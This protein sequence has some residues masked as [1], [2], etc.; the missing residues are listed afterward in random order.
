MANFIFYYGVMGSGKTTELIKTYEIYK[1]KGLEPIVIKP[2]ID[3]REGTYSG[4]GVTTSRLL[5]NQ[6]IPAYYFKKL[7]NEL[8]K[9]DYKTILVDEAQ[10]MSRED[11]LFLSKVVEKEKIKVLAYGLKTDSNGHLFPGS[12]A[13]LTFADKFQELE[14]LCE[15]PNCYEKA[16]LHNRYI[17]GKL[18]ISNTQVAIEKGNVTYKA[19]CRKHWLDNLKKGKNYEL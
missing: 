8:W 17:D 9:L 18:D 12:E 4:W 5:K 7:R 11:V 10:F 16:I 14:A 1:H 19:V 3:D 13:L 15:E 6:S 2:C